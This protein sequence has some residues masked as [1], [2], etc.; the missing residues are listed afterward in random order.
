MNRRHFLASL[1]A[2]PIVGAADCKSG[3]ESHEQRI[4]RVYD[5]ISNA[6]P[7]HWVAVPRYKA[8]T[9]MP[10]IHHLY[11]DVR[12]GDRFFVTGTAFGDKESLD[13]KTVA[14]RILAAISDLH[15]LLWVEQQ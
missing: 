14:S 1:S 11:I 3:Q 10:C 15:E 12:I 7:T 13:D 9:D 2:I 5:E 6:I 4:L 8:W